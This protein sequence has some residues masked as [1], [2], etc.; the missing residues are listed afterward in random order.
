MYNVSIR[1]KYFAFITFNTFIYLLILLKNCIK[2]I[3]VKYIRNSME[4]YLFRY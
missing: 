1:N 3:Q 4:K 2:Y